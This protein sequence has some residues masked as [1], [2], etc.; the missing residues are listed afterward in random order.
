MAEYGLGA[1][2]AGGVAAKLGLFGKIG[3]LLLAGKKFVA[4]I[5]VALL[6]ALKRL[7]GS[8]KQQEPG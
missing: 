1:L 5:V 8:K 7:F 4:V 3:A 2:V 6:A